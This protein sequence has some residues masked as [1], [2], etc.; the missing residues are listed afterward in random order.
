MSPS[1]PPQT[2]YT[3]VQYP[4]YD[5]EM[6]PYSSSDIQHI[7]PDKQHT[8]QKPLQSHD[9][10][11]SSEWLMDSGATHHVTPDLNDLTPSSAYKGKS[12]VMVGNGHQLRIAH[13]GQTILGS[14]TKP[15]VLNQVLH[16]PNLSQH[17]VSVSKMCHDNNVVIE[18]HSDC[19]CVKDKETNQTILQGPASQGLYRL[20]PL[21]QIHPKS[22]G[23][24]TALLTTHNGADPYTWHYRLGHSN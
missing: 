24:P 16:T 6:P 1:I 19:F 21:T 18:F 2:H 10:S 12:S 17:L 3:H 20:P 14:K 5:P 11:H 13:V 22:P 23:S 15:I 4:F 9:L 7:P 8:L